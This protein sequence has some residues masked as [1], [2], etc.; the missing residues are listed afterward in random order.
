MYICV[1][2]VDAVTK[3]PCTEAPMC[4]GPTFPAVKGLQLLWWN[5]TEWPTERPLFYGT[6]DDDADTSIPGVIRTMTEEQYL[7][8]RQTE[9]NLQVMRVR[10]NRDF[11]LRSE[12]DA[13]N[14]IRWELLSEEEKE[15]WR[16]YRQALLDVP[17]QEG[18]PWSI[19]WPVKP[20]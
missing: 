2:H 17:Q 14:P 18:F 10:D 9:D 6:C 5:E 19:E 15:A 13:L 8:L 12:V 16:V 3:I 7:S 20:T 1:T 4:H 11:L